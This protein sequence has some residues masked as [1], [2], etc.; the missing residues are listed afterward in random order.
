MRKNFL[1]W[2][3]LILVI[4]GGINWGLVGIFN[5]D[6]VNWLFS[7]IAWLQNLIYILV[8]V[9]ALYLISFFFRD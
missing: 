9:S 1:D 4:I 3:A 8:G 7:S 6:L 5:F 2:I